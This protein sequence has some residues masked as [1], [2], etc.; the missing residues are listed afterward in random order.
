[1]CITYFMQLGFKI[2][3][4]HV[5]SRVPIYPHVSSFIHS[6]QSNRIPLYHDFSIHTSLTAHIARWRKDQR[7]LQHRC[8]AKQN[9][10]KGWKKCLR[11]D[12]KH[13]KRWDNSGHCGSNCWK[14]MVTTRFPGG[15]SSAPTL[16]A[17]D[18][19]S[20]GHFGQGKIWGFFPRGRIIHLG[21][22]VNMFV[23]LGTCKWD[24]LL[25][26][27]VVSRLTSRYLTIPG[28]VLQ[29]SP[30]IVNHHFTIDLHHG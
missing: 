18:S 23:G 13:G 27:D 29:V 8:G 30:P 25:N 1:M 26:E 19:Q 12:Q 7:R 28:M 2:V 9:S 4:F 22:V 17:N 14:P 3:L 20:H 5:S 15:N 10:W 11:M 16:I 24:H 6:I 21:S